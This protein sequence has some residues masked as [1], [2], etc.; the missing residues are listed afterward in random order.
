MSDT[1]RHILSLAEFLLKK[2]GINGF[3]YKDIAD[4]LNVKNAAI[5]YHFSA[6]ENL[7]KAVIQDNTKRFKAKVEKIDREGMNYLESLE[8]YLKVF[9]DNVAE[10]HQIC[11]FGSLGSDYYNL[12]TSVQHEIRIFSKL[13]MEWLTNL[14]NEGK[15]AG[16]FD[17]QSSAKTMALMINSCMAGALQLTRMSDKAEFYEVVNGIYQELGIKKIN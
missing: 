12:S 10:D 13:I 9:S 11:L 8:E 17:F 3:S 16:V 1:K 14:L 2:K 4:A 15:K 6:K 7:I 5:H